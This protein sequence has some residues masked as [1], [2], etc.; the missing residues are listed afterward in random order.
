MNYSEDILTNFNLLYQITKNSKNIDFKVDLTKIEQLLNEQLPKALKKYNYGHFF[1]VY[2]TFKA[3]YEKFKDFIFYDKLIDKNVVALGGGFSSGKS[4]FLNCLM[5]KNV[6]PSDI[7]PSTVVP[8][9][10]VS[11]DCHD[12]EAVNVFGNK[13]KLQPKMI[14]KIS[15]GFGK[16]ENFEENTEDVKLNHLLKNIFFCTKLNKYDR[17][18]FLDTPGYSKPD[19]K[20]YMHKTDAEV[21]RIQLNSSDFIFWFIQA[22]SGTITEEDI[23]FIKTIKTSIPK[24]F[25]INK[26]DKKTKDELEKI[27][28]KIK[29]MLKK[30]GIK[31]VDILTFSNVEPEAY[32]FYKIKQY[33]YFFQNYKH[34]TKFLKSFKIIFYKILNF[35]KNELNAEKRRFNRLN[36]VKNYD[37]NDY[38][39]DYLNF[40]NNEI[41]NKIN[42]LEDAIIELKKVEVEVIN[43]LRNILLSVNI[44]FDEPNEQ[45]IKKLLLTGLYKIIDDY[46]GKKNIT[47]K[48]FCEEQLL[49]FFDELTSSFKNIENSMQYKIDVF[50]RVKH[51]IKNI[52]TFKLND[53]Y[54][55][56]KIYYDIIREI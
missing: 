32:D 4:S 43:E 54:K 36:N 3:E 44:E 14:K 11:G 52:K 38:N 10:V 17:I 2:N 48:S 8:T 34:K 7:D 22:D 19:I 21:A 35:Y 26:A 56:S 30:R 20:K 33:L 13:I 45:D 1:Q 31:F 39:N 12:I 25:I 49:E 29:E 24:F 16:I 40:F 51:G 23:R 18:A 46:K 37:E 28:Q 9:Y 41:K 15:Y 50:K 6:L 47:T 27:S 53:V 42:L 55:T 5:G